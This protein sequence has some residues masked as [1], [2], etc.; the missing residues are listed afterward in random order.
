MPRFLL[1][2]LNG[3]RVLLGTIA[4]NRRQVQSRQRGSATAADKAPR[5][6]QRVNI[7]IVALSAR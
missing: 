3:L 1:F 4:Y 7:I 2:R 5:E 6:D